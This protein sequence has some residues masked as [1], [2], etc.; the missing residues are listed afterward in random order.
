MFLMVVSGRN[1]GFYVSSSK[2]FLLYHSAMEIFLSQ[3]ESYLGEND[4]FNWIL[5]I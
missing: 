5:E 4:L 1:Q 3:S 2:L